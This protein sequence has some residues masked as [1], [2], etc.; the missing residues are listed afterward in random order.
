MPVGQDR[1]FCCCNTLRCRSKPLAIKIGLETDWNCAIS[2]RDLEGLAHDPHSMTSK[3]Y[4]DWDV[5]AQMP[6]GIDAIRKHL[7]EVDN[8]PLLVSLYTDATTDTVRQM[9]EIFRGFGETV[10]TIGSGYRQSNRD[11]FCESDIAI[12]V[13]M[14]PGDKSELPVIANAVLEKYPSYVSSKGLCR[15]DISLVFSLIGAGALPLLQL[16]VA[17]MGNLIKLTEN[18]VATSSTPEAV[19][20]EDQKQV[21]L[22]AMLESIREGRVVL[23]NM[24]QM[25]SVIVI[26]TVC[27]ALWQLV[28]LA[29]PTTIPPTLPPPLALLFVVLYIPGKIGRAHV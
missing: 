1:D 8:V 24:F 5:K 3:N 25:I 21:R 11:I 4:A 27:L 2:L 16:P 18:N 26:C 29:V 14:L 12:S 17:Y 22:S 15:S 7:F 10:M 6:H 23:L 13:S 9:I 28:A 20:S 19:G